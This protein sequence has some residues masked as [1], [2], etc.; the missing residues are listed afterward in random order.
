MHQYIIMIL[1]TIDPLH[2]KVHY[3]RSHLND[4]KCFLTSSTSYTHENVTLVIPKL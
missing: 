2:I 4:N 1:V 3:F